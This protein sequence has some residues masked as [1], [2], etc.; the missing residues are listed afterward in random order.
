[1]NYIHEWLKYILISK[2]KI[3]LNILSG[4]NYNN[5]SIRL[6]DENYNCCWYKMAQMRNTLLFSFT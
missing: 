3:L 4:A 5:M 1:M 6:Y 2:K